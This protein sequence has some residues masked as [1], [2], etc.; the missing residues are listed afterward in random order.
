MIIRIEETIKR[1]IDIGSRVTV[2][3][4][5]EELELKYNNVASIHAAIQNMT[6]REELDSIQEGKMLLR[7]K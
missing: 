6:R 1:R 3:K 7:K 5:M 2:D 4:L